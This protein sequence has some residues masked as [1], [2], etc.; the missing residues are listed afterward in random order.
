MEA[1]WLQVTC[2]GRLVSGSKASL[3][4]SASVWRPLVPSWE[5]CREDTRVTSWEGA[6]RRCWF[7]TGFPSSLGRTRIPGGRAW[8]LVLSVAFSEM[9]GNSDIKTGLLEMV[10]VVF[11]SLSRSLG[12]QLLINMGH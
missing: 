5:A 7:L 2:T 4:G 9:L 8:L 11:L 10:F 3:E 6:G 12:L 1:S